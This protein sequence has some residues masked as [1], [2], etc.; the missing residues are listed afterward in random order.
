M[1][2]RQALHQRALP[3]PILAH[4]GDNFALEERR[5]NVVQ[6]VN[7]EESLMD[8]SCFDEWCLLQ[9]GLTFFKLVDQTCATLLRI[10]HIQNAHEDHDLATLGH[11]LFHETT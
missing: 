3:G 11:A 6:C 5:G 2:A 10:E 7:R 1:N 8:S 4:H 9:L